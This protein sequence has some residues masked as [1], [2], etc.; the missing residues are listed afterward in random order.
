MTD[1]TADTVA[2]KILSSAELEILE[3]D[4]RFDGSQDDLADGFIHLSTAAQL[5]GTL[6]RHF[7][8]RGDLAI[9][10]VDL[11]AAEALRWEPSRDGALFPHLYAPLTL[12]LAL[13]YG[14]LERADDGSVRL[15]VAG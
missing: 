6:S 3:R 15:P 10:A 7:A 14:P 5:E 9:V 12:D 11:L 13:A 8:E 1:I 4:G 2:Y